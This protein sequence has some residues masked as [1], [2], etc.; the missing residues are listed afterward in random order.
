MFILALSCLNFSGAKAQC[1][2][3]DFLF[4]AYEQDIK[5]MAIRR[6]IEVNSPDQ[7]KITIPQSWQDTIAGDLAAIYQAD[8]IPESD[9]VFNLYCVH[10]V[11]GN[12]V[13]KNFLLGVEEGTAMDSAWSEGA[14]TTGVTLID[15]IFSEYEVEIVSHSDLYVH[16]STPYYINIFAL[17]DTLVNNVPGVLY[18]EPNFIIGNAGR[19]EYSVNESGERRYDFVYQWNDCFDGCDNYHTW[20]FSVNA[21]CEV[22][23]L[24]LD[25]GGFFGVE[26]LPAPANCNLTSS[27]EDLVKKG[28]DLVVYPNPSRG[29]LYLS[30]QPENGEWKISNLQGQIL[31][32]GSFPAEQ[33]RLVNSATGFYFL[34]WRSQNSLTGGVGKI[35]LI[36]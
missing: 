16:F 28:T 2:Y 1:T 14:I 35:Q 25:R 27:N 23:Y 22:E 9:S 5:A 13:L 17:A 33:I 26:D 19:I 34:Q 6:M 20:S 24:G 3:P 32:E 11:V 12:P 18:L 29:L 4:E 31:Q 7:Y 8:N 21:D 36:E 30:G 15:D 10:D